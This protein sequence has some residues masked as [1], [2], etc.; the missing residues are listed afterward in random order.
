MTVPW[1]I[2]G[3]SLLYFIFIIWVIAST[4]RH[5]ANLLIVF[6]DKERKKNYKNKNKFQ[7]KFLHSV[8][9]HRYKSSDKISSAAFSTHSLHQTPRN[10]LVIGMI[11][12]LLS[13]LSAWLQSLTYF[14]FLSL[15]NCLFTR[16]KSLYLINCVE[17][18]ERNGTVNK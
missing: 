4:Y 9:S 15:H 18:V 16:W 14:L 7:L 17:N 1:V 12:P 5:F 11:S 13:C 2:K 10:S 3:F 8:N 6:K